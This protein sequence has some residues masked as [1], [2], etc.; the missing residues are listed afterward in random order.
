LQIHADRFSGHYEVKALLMK[1]AYKNLPSYS[2]VTDAGVTYTIQ[3]DAFAI[4]TGYLDLQA[5][6]SATII[7]PSSISALSPTA[8]YDASCGCVY[9]VQNSATLVEAMLC[10]E[11]MRFGAPVLL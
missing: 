4:G 8:T 11:P 3:Y 9:F 6:T 1:T 7:P 5:A 10:G 2:T